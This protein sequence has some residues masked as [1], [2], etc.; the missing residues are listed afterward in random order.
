MKIGITYDLRD[1]YIEAGYSEEATAEFDRRDTIQAIE[2]T[3]QDL[4]YETD[5][6][7]N[8]HNLMRRLLDGQRWDL[9]FN[10]AEGLSGFGR[11]GLVPSLLDAYGIPYT[12]SDPLI[13]S[14]TLH[15]A[16]AKRVV[17][18]L[19]IP[20]PEFFVIEKE[21]KEFT[22]YFPFPLFA[23]PVAEGTSK[24]ISSASKIMNTIQLTE[25][26]NKLL[27]NFNQPVLVEMYL[28]GREFTVGIIGTGKEATALGVMEVI[29]KDNADPEVYSYANKEYCEE[30]VEY[31]LVDDITAQRTQKLALAVWRGLGCKDAGRVDFRVDRKGMPN[32]LEVNPLAGLHPEHSDLCII[33]SKTGMTYHKLIESILLSTFKRYPSINKAFKVLAHG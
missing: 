18:D 19:G 31:R 5:C 22:G 11:E 23:K 17:R 24:G 28:P 25:V 13:L 6:I 32:F 12:F 29:L 26:C 10:I 14:L 7:G 27:L 8:F 30:L 2:S 20:T 4:G 16:M 21:K 9:V 1:D 15:K 33:A 3:L